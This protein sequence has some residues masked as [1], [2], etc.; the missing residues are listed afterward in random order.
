LLLLLLLLLRPGT[1]FTAMPSVA[2]G[3]ALSTLLG[4]ALSLLGSRAERRKH[5]DATPCITWGRG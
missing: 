3:I 5:R 2:A 1:T 4:T